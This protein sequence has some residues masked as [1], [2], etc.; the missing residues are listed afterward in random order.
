MKPW[1]TQCGKRSGWGVALMSPRLLANLF[2]AGLK[3]SCGQG[4]A[5]PAALILR[6]A[7]RLGESSWQV[8][9]RN[10]PLIVQFRSGNSV[11]RDS[12]MLIVCHKIAENCCEISFFN[13]IVFLA[14]FCNWDN[15]RF[16]TNVSEF[17]LSFFFCFAF[18]EKKK[19][20][21]VISQSS[22]LSP[23]TPNSDQH[24]ISHN[25]I[26]PEWNMRAQD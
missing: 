26:T 15:K 3:S 5:C 25:N 12:W 1:A 17:Y 4:N 8:T 11:S 7:R 14:M 21:S 6:L 13:K 2:P 16:V 22:A 19:K 23:L 10:L 9:L 24:L 20:K 18:F